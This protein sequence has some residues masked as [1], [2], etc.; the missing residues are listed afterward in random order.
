LME[1][2][3]ELVEKAGFPSGVFNVVYGAHDVVNTLLQDPLV[4]GI[5]FVGS[6]NVGEYVYREGTKNLKRVQ[7]L[8]GAKNHVVVLK[9]ANIDRAVKDL[10][11]GAFGSAG[12]RCMAASVIV[13]EEEIADQFVEKFKAA[14]KAIK[15]GNGL[16]EGVFLGPVIRKDAQQRAFDYIQTGVADGSKLVLDGRENIPT[17]GYFVGTTIL[18]ID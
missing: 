3:V 12:E 8:T 4:K 5:S 14:A 13:L 15:I 9:D 7:A 2:I 6:K 10:I 11:G 1:K 18:I 16:D 17:K